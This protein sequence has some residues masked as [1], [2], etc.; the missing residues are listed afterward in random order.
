V[1]AAATERKS[2]VFCHYRREMT[3]LRDLLLRGGGVGGVGGE[4][5]IAII[6]GRVGSRERE[7]IL[8]AAP[9]VLILQIRTCS[10]GLNLQSYSDVY[11]VSPHW[12]PYVEDQAIA[13]CYRMGQTNQVRVF[14]FYMSD[15]VGEVGAVAAGV[16]EAVEAAGAV[17]AGVVEAGVVEAVEAGVVE[18]GAGSISTLDHKCEEI[19]ERKRLLCEGFLG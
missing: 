9:K 11:F 19:Q 13:R 2:L 5:D 1:A 7:R 6:D 4:D 15:F 18:A 10:E 17:E 14:R 3:R 16:V 12:N 8:A